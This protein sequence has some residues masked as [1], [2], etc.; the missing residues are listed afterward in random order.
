MKEL[1][2]YATVKVTPEVHAQAVTP[3]KRKAQS[4]VVE[5]LKAAMR[6]F[7]YWT[8]NGPSVFSQ[9]WNLLKELGPAGRTDDLFHAISD[10]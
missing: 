6:Q 3:A 8:P 7:V 4:K 2:R 9:Q 10:H 5:L 1:L